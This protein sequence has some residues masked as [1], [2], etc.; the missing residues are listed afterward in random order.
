MHIVEEGIPQ[1]TDFD[2]GK[3]AVSMPNYAPI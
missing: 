2:F 1:G 3:L